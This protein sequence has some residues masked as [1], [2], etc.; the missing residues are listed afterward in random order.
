M[1]TTPMNSYILIKKLP[2][3]VDSG[4]IKM[5]PDTLNE[6]EIDTSDIVLQNNKITGFE[7]I[8]IGG[9]IVAEV[10][11]V[12]ESVTDTLNCEN[13]HNIHGICNDV[14]INQDE[15]G[16]SNVS[17]NLFSSNNDDD[18][19]ESSIAFYINLILFF[20]ILAFNIPFKVYFRKKRKNKVISER[21]H[22]FCKK[23]LLLTPYINSGAF[24][25]GFIVLQTSKFIEHAHSGNTQNIEHELFANLFVIM[26]ISSL[27][28]VLFTFFW[29]KHLVHFKYLEHVYS[30]EELSKS[31]HF[32][33]EP[34][35]MF[36]LMLVQGI[37]TLLPLSIV[38]FYIF[39]SLSTPKELNIGDLNSS[40]FD[41][42]MGNYKKLISF[43]DIPENEFSI[44][45][46]VPYVNSIDTILASFGIISGVIVSII[47]ILNFVKWQTI[48]ITVPL[49][50][51]INKMEQAS[52]TKHYQ[53]ATVRTKDEI[54]KLTEGYNVM[55]S[56]IMGYIVEIEAMNEGLEQKVKDRTAEIEAQRDEIMAQRDEIEAQ[57]DEIITQRDFVTQQRDIISFQ[58]KEITDSINYALRIQQAILPPDNIVNQLLPNNFI[59]YQPKDIVCGDFYFVDKIN[60]TVIFAVVDCTGHGVP[61]ALMSVI[62]FSLLNQA[63]KANKILK[64]S[65]IL[66]Y[67]DI[68]VN[69]TL[70]QSDFESGVSDGMDLAICTV[71]NLRNTSETFE[72]QYAGAYNSLIYVKNNELF[73]IKADKFPIGCNPNGEADNFT[74]HVVSLNKG[75]CIYLYSDG[76][77]DQFGGTLGKKFKYKP[78]K[79][80]L[81]L[82]HKSDVLEQKRIIENTFIKWKEGFDQ[83]DDVLIM[84]VKI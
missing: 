54:G 56:K 73:E 26:I 10:D 65:E 3:L 83:V 8:A 33:K 61:G 81:L 7:N 72:L 45:S 35:I 23:Y 34:R 31:L 12:T 19:G 62:G 60:D 21:L 5:T 74:N 58:K 14:T 29:Q 13:I 69:D 1:L 53:F 15:N 77:A 68:G 42:L 28:I 36:Q 84:G 40:H 4:L 64:P 38:V 41:I 67:L 6:D 78:L 55:S 80:M 25:F 17:I 43:T 37:T 46:N 79:E 27:L 71:T 57:R 70:R 32:I 16:T 75:N 24:L 48:Q 22:D 50:S 76:Y 2:L 30:K 39:L 82:H 59:F 18:E 9:G 11:T 49:T 63:V 51:L 66:K 44:I 20:A 52:E 47:Y